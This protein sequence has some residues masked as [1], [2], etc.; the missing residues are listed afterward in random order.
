MP[1]PFSLVAHADHAPIL[2]DLEAHPELWDQHT[3]RRDVLK[4]PFVKASDIWVRYNR[5]DRLGPQFNDEHVPVWY[6]AWS[7]LPSLKPVV[8]ALMAQFQGEML[9]GVLI[10][11][12]PAGVSIAPHVD[13]GWH[14]D[15]YEKFYLSLK[16][17]PGAMFCFDDAVLNPKPGEVWRIDNRQRHWVAN[18]S[19]EDR[20]TLIVCIR[21]EMFGRR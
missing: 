3:A 20:M 6:P 13:T 19:N 5:W 8:F 4:S 2:R 9:G 15:Y 18:N 1:S 11:R 14:V 16:S 10:T 21:T 7:A 12:I 17:A